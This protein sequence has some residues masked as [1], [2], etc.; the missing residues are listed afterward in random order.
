MEFKSLSENQQDTNKG[1]DFIR[2][3]YC[4]EDVKE[5]IRLME[6]WGCVDLSED[7]LTISYA[8]FKELAGEKLI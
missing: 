7:T 3:A 4:E 6:Y 5:F 8:K 2:Y 1:T